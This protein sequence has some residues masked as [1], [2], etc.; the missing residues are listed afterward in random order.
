MQATTQYVSVQCST[1]QD[2][3]HYCSTFSSRVCARNDA[4][5]VAAHDANYASLATRDSAVDNPENMHRVPSRSTCWQHCSLTVPG[6][7]P[8]T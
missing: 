1:L 3:I 8:V 5:Y 4:M 6:R 7:A 2:S